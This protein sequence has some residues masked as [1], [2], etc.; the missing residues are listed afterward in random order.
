MEHES[1]SLWKTFHSI[2]QK[3]INNNLLTPNSKF[4]K[5]VE[6]LQDFGVPLEV[7][8]EKWLNIFQNDDNMI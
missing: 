4:G 7:K 8:V 3:L 6:D 1:Y 5:L 2:H